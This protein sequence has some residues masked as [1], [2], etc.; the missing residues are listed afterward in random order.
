MSNISAIAIVGVPGSG[1]TTLAQS[2]CNDDKV[3]LHF[4]H[5]II[6][7]CVSDLLSFSDI[8][9]R[10]IE[11]E[12]RGRDSSVSSLKPPH[13][14]L[15]EEISGK[16][17]LLVL[18]DLS[19][20]DQFIWD[21]LRAQLDIGAPGSKILITTRY[22]NVGKVVATTD[23]IYKLGSLSDNDALLLFKRF[24]FSGGEDQEQERIGEDIVSMCENSPL[25]LR[26]AANHVAQK[27]NWQQLRV[28]IWT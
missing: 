22:Q 12:S 4:E 5:K 14:Q 10:I 20:N 26:M 15:L 23:N 13:E 25:I 3:E 1:K 27:N 6:W 2:I 11:S 19:T 18:D 16:K 7:A 21:S 17:Y 9:T 24:A 8:L 28:E